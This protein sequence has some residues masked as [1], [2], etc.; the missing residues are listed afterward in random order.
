M[1][2]NSQL[3]LN[4]KTMANSRI[5]V[6]MANLLQKLLPMFISFPNLRL[7]LL[8]L[9]PRRRE[10]L[11]LLSIAPQLQKVEGKTP[12]SG[13]LLISLMVSTFQ[14]VMGLEGRSCLLIWERNC[15]K[16]QPSEIKTRLNSWKEWILRNL[17]LMAEDVPILVNQV[18]LLVFALTSI[19]IKILNFPTPTQFWRGSLTA[20][21]WVE[22]SKEIVLLNLLIVQYGLQVQLTHKWVIYHMT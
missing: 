17:L 7:L 12:W 22:I 13:K 16:P 11:L 6:H 5:K 8:L 20:H 10:G 3:Q 15:W 9:A 21:C 1:E 19:T 18:T 14:Q 2:C 4:L